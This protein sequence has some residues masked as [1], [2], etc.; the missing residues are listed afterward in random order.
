HQERFLRLTSGPTGRARCRKRR[1][2]DKGSMSLSGFK[3]VM[4]RDARLWIPIARLR[5]K[6]KNQRSR[7]AIL[8]KR[9]TRIRQKAAFIHHLARLQRTIALPRLPN[10]NPKSP[11]RISLWLT[12]YRNVQ[13]AMTTAG[14]TMRR[15]LMS[16]ERPERERRAE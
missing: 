15:S 8:Q 1:Q 14:M 4:I 13:S 7:D 11:T 9:V 2:G 10:A 3:G 6:A 16:R 5:W 12:T